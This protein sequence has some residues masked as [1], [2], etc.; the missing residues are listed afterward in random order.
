MI[1]ALNAFFIVQCC[2]LMLGLLEIFNSIYILNTLWFFYSGAS[3]R[4]HRCVTNKVG[5]HPSETN[6]EVF[7]CLNGKDLLSNT[8]LISQLFAC[9]ERRLL[10]KREIGWEVRPFGRGCPPHQKEPVEVIQASHKDAPW[11]PS[12]WDVPDT[13][14]WET[15]P[16]QTQDT[17]LRLLPSRP[18]PR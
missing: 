8:A 6:P 13:S 5:S 3:S 15:A 4:F 17:L 10:V 16:G 7:L 18:G 14:H 1:K 11:V 9:I 2:C 12:G